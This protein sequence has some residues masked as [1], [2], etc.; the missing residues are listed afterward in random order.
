[1]VY[2]V[3]VSS[4]TIWH[5]FHFLYYWQQNYSYPR[6]HGMQSANKN[7]NKWEVK[8]INMAKFSYAE[9]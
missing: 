5:E 9:D 7:N 8:I 3:S 1:M 6:K 4:F 2:S